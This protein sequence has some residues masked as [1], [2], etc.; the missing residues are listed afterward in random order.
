[1]LILGKSPGGYDVVESQTKI[2][3]CYT[4]FVDG[5]FILCSQK[6]KTCNHLFTTQEVQKK[7]GFDT[8]GV[9]LKKCRDCGVITSRISIPRFPM[10]PF[11]RPYLPMMERQKRR[12]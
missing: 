8:D 11:Y 5:T 6:K 2:E 7:A 9:L 3:G 4:L 10:F 12:K 1:M